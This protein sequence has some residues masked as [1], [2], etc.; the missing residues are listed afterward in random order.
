MIVTFVSNEDPSLDLYF[1]RFR[2]EPCD[3]LD[4]SAQISVQTEIS[5]DSLLDVGG[6][7]FT[8]AS[9][10]TLATPKGIQD[11]RLVILVGAPLRIN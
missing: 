1:I 11:V 5:L 6:S 2:E 9:L 10:G 4:R 8:G 7:N 3:W